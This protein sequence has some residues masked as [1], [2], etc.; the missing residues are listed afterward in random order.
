MNWK[1]FINRLWTKSA[2]EIASSNEHDVN[3]KHINQEHTLPAEPLTH[4]DAKIQQWQTQFDDVADNADRTEI[5]IGFDFG[6]AFSKVVIS[7]VGQK[8]G[9]PLNDN[10]QGIDKYLLPTRLYEDSTGN[11]LLDKP[12]DCV[13]P[14]IEHTDLKMRILD[15]KL[16]DDTKKRI[17]TYIVAVLQKSRYWLMT[18]KRAVID[19]FKLEW[20]VNIGL[21]TEKYDDEI[22]RKTYRELVGEAWKMSTEPQSVGEGDSKHSTERALHPDMI[23]AFPEFVAQIQ[24]YISSPQRQAGI[25]T[26]VDVGAGTIDATIFIVHQED[27]ENRHPI[28]AGSVRPLGTAYLIKHRC[29]ALVQPNGWQLNPYD[30]FPND[31]E[32][33]DTLGVS[34]DD[35]ER[36][37]RA[38]RGNIA[39]DQIYSILEQAHSDH[40]PCDNIKK[41]NIPGR[42]ATEGVP[43]ML[44]GG[45][46]SVNFYQQVVEILTQ[47]GHGYL[48]YKKHLSMGD[49]Q[50]DAPD[51]LKEDNHRLSVAY[52]LSFNALNIG[53]ISHPPPIPAN[54]NQRQPCPLCRGTGGYGNCRKCGGSGRL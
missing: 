47:R 12:V 2:K 31:A 21:P 42:E 51:I 38:F 53:K 20:A 11:Y 32:F 44:C 3:R 25:H 4:K 24:G 37:D 26:L 34:L 39:E 1:R 16:D 36:V 40:D 33:A 27:G 48:L 18:E 23:E 6:T 28:L 46:A 52:G 50:Y 45:G 10:K 14:H 19:G 9:V 43:L 29:D 17:I 30:L 41:D 15:N 49:D 8:Y 13:S 54:N 5:I 35:I 22:L 7:G